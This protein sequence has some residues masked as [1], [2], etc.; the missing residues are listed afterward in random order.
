MF[1]LG[2]KIMV[3]GHEAWGEGE[4]IITYH[5]DYDDNKYV[6]YFPNIELSLVTW[7]QD[8][9]YQ[10]ATSKFKNK[11]TIRSAQDNDDTFCSPKWKSDAGL[12]CVGEFNLGTMRELLN[13]ITF[14][15]DNDIM[16]SIT[17]YKYTEDTAVT[18]IEW[19]DGTKTTVRAEYPDTASPYTGF[20]TACAKKAF[21]NNNTIN[22]LFDEWAVKKPKRET[23]AKIKANAALLEEKRIA[24]NRKTKREKWLIHKRAAEIAKEYEARKL[25]NEKYGV[26][27]DEKKGE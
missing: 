21:G 4:I 5:D 23:E 14:K 24:E 3:R 6:V 27:M 8:S 22:K 16:P 11:S 10:M 17:N 18:T 20:V 15:G 12:V 19:S 7:S 1:E 26:P 9:F 2:N 13:K 25:A